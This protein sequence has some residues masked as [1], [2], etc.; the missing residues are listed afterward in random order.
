M[1]NV[2]RDYLAAKLPQ[3]FSRL[4]RWGLLPDPWAPASH[5][6]IGA[7][8]SGYMERIEGSYSPKQPLAPFTVAA[9]DDAAASYRRHFERFDKDSSGNIQFG[10]IHVYDAKLWP[11][12]GVH[13]SHAGSFRDV[14]CNIAALANPKYE[15]PRLSLPYLPEQTRYK[16]AIFLG[17]AWW[18]NH[19]HWMIDIL[20]RLELVQAELA[21]GLPVIV[22]P[23][24]G[25]AQLNAVKVVLS[26][27]GYGGTEIIQPSVRVCAFDMLVMPTQMASP[28]DISPRQREF[29]RAAFLEQAPSPQ[30]GRRIYI[31]RRDAA[32]RRISNEDELLPI[33]ARRGFECVQLT[34][35]SLAEQVSLFQQAECVVGHHGAGFTNTVFC[36]PG[37]TL[38]EI[39]QDGH[40][41]PMFARLAQLGGLGY[42]YAVGAPRNQDTEID[43][44]TVTALLDRLGVD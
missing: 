42:G 13:A 37:A 39:F 11:S 26:A 16:S 31:S 14:Y 36:S 35:L 3:A 10:V 20:P 41:A 9:E 2:A 30:A 5:V 18:H 7:G 15:V 29:L 32:I 19:Y 6:R 23:G 4:Q 25:P 44:R 27:M 12:F 24:L 21:E 28:L 38:V 8:G 22:P 43:T 33:L 40:F 34:R 1:G 17:V